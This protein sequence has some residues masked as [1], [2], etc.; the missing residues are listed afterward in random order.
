[1]RGGEGPS[2]AV[3]IW[4]DGVLYFYKTRAKEEEGIRYQFYERQRAQV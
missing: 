2:G 4:T 1:M 3:T